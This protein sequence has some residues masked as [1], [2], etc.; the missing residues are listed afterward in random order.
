M[1]VEKEVTDV[2]EVSY[3]D[4]APG[5]RR[6]SRAAEA[7]PRYAKQSTELLMKKVKQLEDKM[8]RHARDLEFEEAARLRDEIEQIRS[9]GLG[10]PGKSGQH[11][12]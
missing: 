6:L 5:R 11:T 12:A 7:A 1:G 2:L 8:Y 4:N 10:M 9:E 3:G